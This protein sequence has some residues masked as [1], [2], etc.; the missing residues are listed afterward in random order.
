M[1]K[2]VK[3]SVVIFKFSDVQGAT[4]A[5]GISGGTGATGPVGSTG[6]YVQIIA[7]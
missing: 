4:G 5:T 6:N 1:I 2:F 3:Y 7:I